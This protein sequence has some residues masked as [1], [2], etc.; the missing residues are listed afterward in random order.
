MRDLV[1]VTIGINEKD[2]QRLHTFENYEKLE[3]CAQA[4]ELSNAIS[5][6]LIGITGTEH[7]IFVDEE[8][9]QVSLVYSAP[10]LSDER[11]RE[12]VE[13]YLSDKER[14]YSSFQESKNEFAKLG[15]EIVVKKTSID[16]TKIMP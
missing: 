5:L 10:D 2:I 11:T 8:R 15:I 13:T 14:L 16:A 4:L 3:M 1:S 6:A 9:M 7:K 12:F